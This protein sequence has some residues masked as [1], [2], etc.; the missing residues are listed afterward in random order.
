MLRIVDLSKSF[1]GLKALDGYH[2][3]LQ[4]GELVGVIG[5]NGAGKTTLFNLISGVQ[6]PSRGHIIFEGRDITRWSP[7]AICRHGIARTFQN[8]RLFRGLTVLDNIRIAMQAHQSTA[9]HRVLLSL[10]SF[11]T[12]ERALTQRAAELAD[13]L[14]L[15]AYHQAHAHSLPYGLQRRLEIAM[16]LATRPRLLLLDEPAAGMTPTEAEAL[17]D[18]IRTIRHTFDLTLILIE[19]NMRLVMQIC[20]RIQVLNYGVLI[21]EGRPEEIRNAPRVLEAYLGHRADHGE[22]PIEPAQA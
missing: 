17:M 3:E 14:G 9:L 7:E 12:S 8:I 21:A 10:P 20:E 16:A 11:A 18:L 5:P 22:A 15:S 6:K 4:A 13:L 1:R 19:H 2:L